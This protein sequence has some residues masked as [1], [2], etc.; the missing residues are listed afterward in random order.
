MSLVCSGIREKR[1]VPSVTWSRSGSVRAL[2]EYITHGFIKHFYQNPL[3]NG[4]SQ[5]A[6]SIQVCLPGRR[7]CWD[8]LLA[9]GQRKKS[10]FLKMRETRVPQWFGATPGS[11]VSLTKTRAGPPLLLWL[12]REGNKRIGRLWNEWSRARLGQPQGAMLPWRKRSHKNGE[13][14]TGS[15]KGMLT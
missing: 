4:S 12:R 10:L 2:D 11:R 14:H 7:M 9:Q 3:V 15:N 5:M 13:N 1:N 6:W 8:E